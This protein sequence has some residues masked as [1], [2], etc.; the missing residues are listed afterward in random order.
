M[1]VIRWPLLLDAHEAQFDE[2]DCINDRETVMGAFG[3]VPRVEANEAELVAD[4]RE[5]NADTDAVIGDC[6]TLN[7]DA[8]RAHLD[9]LAVPA[10]EPEKPVEVEWFGWTITGLVL[11]VIAVAFLTALGH[12]AFGDE[13]KPPGSW[14]MTITSMPCHDAYPQVPALANRLG[15]KPGAPDGGAIVISMC[16]GDSYDVITMINAALDR[17]DAA[18]R[19]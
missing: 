17:L 4:L 8:I 12:F 11:G 16:N 5:L 1:T 10:G 2:P 7:A 3:I 18:T 9:S 13:L 14:S 19:R 6:V 15:V